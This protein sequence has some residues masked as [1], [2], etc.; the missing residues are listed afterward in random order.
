MPGLG[1]GHRRN[2]VEGRGTYIADLAPENA[3]EACFVRSLVGHARITGIELGTGSGVTGR[4]LGLNPLTLEGRGLAAIPWRPLAVDTVRYVGEPL[5][6]VWAEDRYLAEDAADQVAV[7]YEEVPAGTPLHAAAPDGVLFASDFDS[8]GVEE[9]M[10]RADRVIER[11]FKAARQSALPLECRGVLADHDSS[12]GVTTVWTSTQIPHLVRR[13]IAAA[14]GCEERAVRVMVPD[15]GGGFGLKAQVSAEEIAVAALARRLSRPVRWIEDRRENLIASYHAHDTRVRLRA[16]VR[17]DGRILG[18]DAEVDAD[19]G[20]YSSWPFSASLEPAT[21]AFTLFG[22]YA[23]EAIRHRTRG[24]ASSRCPVGAHRGVGMNAG[25]FATERMVDVLALELGLDPLEMRRRNAVR[26][27]P[28]VTAGG[29][30]LDSGDYLELLGRLESETG[31]ADLR[32]WQAEER[33][34]G[35]LIGLGIGFFNE[36]SGTGSADYRRRGVTAIPGMDAARVRVTAEGRLEIYTSAADAGQGHADTYRR[37]AELEVGLPPEQVDVI[38]GDTDLCP[39]GTG[40]FASRGA[41]GVASSVAQALRRAAEQDL[42]PGTDLTVVHDPTQVFPSGAHL[43]VVEVDPVG[44]VPRVI[45]YVAVEDCGTIIHP[46]LVDEQ[47]RGGVATGIGDVLLEEHVYS[48]DGQILSATLLDYLPPLAPDVPEIEIHHLSS[49]SPR[50]QVG[51]KGVGEAGTI[52]AFGA[53]ANAVADA[54]RPLGA[55]LG[56]LPYSPA[57]IFESLPT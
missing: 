23:V 38:E 29:R 30:Q 2:L 37:L 5:G 3:V 49:P 34:R 32:R 51:S 27:L 36:H 47:V 18:I 31:Y 56:D 40:T 14:V 26:E 13:G 8:G 7:D 12:T 57:R 50:S 35:R 42:L 44:L 33:G 53:V 21:A 10:A 16:G 1:P 9:A 39:E 22:A 17:A 48:E 43:A 4:D 45:R 11:S 54:V 46:E 28:T 25:V 41:V 6:V 19:V 55:E 15:V 20:A 24:L 52:G